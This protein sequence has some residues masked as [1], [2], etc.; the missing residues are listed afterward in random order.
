VQWILGT[1]I[2]GA[3]S[4]CLTLILILFGPHAPLFPFQN[5]CPPKLIPRDR[6]VHAPAV[7]EEKEDVFLSM[8]FPIKNSSHYYACNMT[9][10]NIASKQ[11]PI[12][13]MA[14][15]HRKNNSWIE[16]LWLSGDFEIFQFQKYILTCPS[17]LCSPQSIMPDTV[18][19]GAIPVSFI[20][21]CSSSQLSH[22]I[23]RGLGIMPDIELG[24]FISYQLYVFIQFLFSY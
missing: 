6:I 20:F 14:C 15:Q 11:L 23:I 10:W 17:L 3:G 21:N 8:F 12:L 18:S 24:P 22:V 7:L 19:C 13:S 2:I 5:N 9:V 16:M 1:I 4:L